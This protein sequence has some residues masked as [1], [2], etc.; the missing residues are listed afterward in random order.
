MA[1]GPT[2]ARNEVLAPGSFEW[3]RIDFERQVPIGFHGF[4]PAVG[5]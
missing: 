3:P 5:W 4:W 1:S 2:Q